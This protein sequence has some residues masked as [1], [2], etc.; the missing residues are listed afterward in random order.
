MTFV[1]DFEPYQ[2]LKNKIRADVDRTNEIIHVVKNDYHKSK[3]IAYAETFQ[4]L[5][6]EVDLL[7][8][9]YQSIYK[10]FKNFQ[11]LNTDRS[12]TFFDTSGRKFNEFIVWNVVAK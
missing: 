3:L 4:S 2:K 11:V 5:Q 6:L 10:T 8:D 9:T 12:K 1:H 7:S